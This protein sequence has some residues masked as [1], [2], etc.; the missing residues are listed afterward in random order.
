MHKISERTQQGIKLPIRLN[1]QYNCIIHD[2]NSLSPN[3]SSQ[4]PHITPKQ[5]TILHT[6]S[7]DDPVRTFTNISIYSIYNNVLTQFNFYYR[8]ITHHI[9]L[10][11]TSHHTLQII[12]T[13][14]I[15]IVIHILFYHSTV[16]FN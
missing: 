6:A 12:L 16:N 13:A 8:I 2:H 11:Y 4:T 1:Q 3:L 5:F 9:Y 15:F 10:L 14:G 7:H